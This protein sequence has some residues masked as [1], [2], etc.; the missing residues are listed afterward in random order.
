MTGSRYS[1]NPTEVRD[2]LAKLGLVRGVPTTPK[3]YTCRECLDS[4]WVEVMVGESYQT[5]GGDVRL[6]VRVVA[7]RDGEAAYRCESCNPSRSEPA[8]ARG[9]QPRRRSA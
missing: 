2:L 8:G 3:F 7:K 1:V 9:Y 5:V 4:G 6:G